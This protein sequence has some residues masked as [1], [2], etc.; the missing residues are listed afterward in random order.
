MQIMRL[1][2]F[3]EGLAQAVEKIEDKRF[4]DL[5]LF[6]RTLERANFPCLPNGSESPTADRDDQQREKNSRPHGIKANLLRR[7]FAVKVLL[8]VIENV[9][10]P[11]KIF[12]SGFA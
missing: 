2:R 4:L 11:W 3:S 7:R 9:F 10:E 6:L 1:D 5:D 8:E 12:R